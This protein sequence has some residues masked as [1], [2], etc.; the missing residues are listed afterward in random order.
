MA[1]DDQ[2]KL[3]FLEGKRP[4]VKKITR[5]DVTPYPRL[6][7]LTSFEEYVDSSLQ[8]EQTLKKHTESGHALLVGNLTRKIT[9][10]S[11]AGL[12]DITRLTRW[13][14]LDFDNLPGYTVTTAM[15]E[16]DKVW[17]EISAATRLVQYSASSGL[18]G[19][20]NLNCH[21]FLLLDELIS[22][23]TLKNFFIHANLKTKFSKYLELNPSGVNIHW[24]L[25]PALAEPSQMIFIADPNFQPESLNP[26]EDDRWVYEKGKVDEVSVQPMLDALPSM[27]ALQ[28]D[29]AKKIRELRKIAGLSNKKFRVVFKDDICHD[30]DP[31]EVTGVKEE[32]GFVYLNLNGGDSWGYYYPEDDPSI[33]RNF[34]GEPNYPLEKIAPDYWNMFV[35]PQKASHVSSGPGTLRFAFQDNHTGKTHTCTY[36]STTQELEISA[37]LSDTAARRWLLSYNLSPKHIHVV[38]INYDPRPSTPKGVDLRLRTINVYQ[39]TTIQPD[40]SKRSAR[41]PPVID[42][43][44]RHVLNQPK[45]S[46]KLNQVYEHF[47]NWLAFIVQAKERTGT[48]WLLH[49]TQGTGKG[50]LMH[51]IIKP[52]LGE[53]NCS[54]ITTNTLAEKF[55][56]RLDHKLFVGVDE[57]SREIFSK[58][59]G[60]LNRLKSMMTEETVTSRKFHGAPVEMLSFINFIL[61]S[62]EQVPIEIPANDRRFNVAYAQ[63]KPLRSA[64]DGSEMKL[65]QAIRTKIPNELPMF[66]R[67]LQERQV[68]RSVVGLAI[69]NIAKR[70]MIAAGRTATQAFFDM[71]RYNEIELIYEEYLRLSNKE[72]A[73]G[74]IMENPMLMSSDTVEKFRV[75]CEQYLFVDIEGITVLTREQ[76]AIL[77]KC[78]LGKKIPTSPNHYLA[79]LSQFGFA[80][81]KQ[82]CEVRK[83]SIK[84]VAIKCHPYI[85][86]S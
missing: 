64:F 78:M 47:L 70:H 34:K 12:T 44:I 40:S 16:L 4:L 86:S 54:V 9:D 55:T 66:L 46:K 17:P 42:L 13:M 29:Q 67:F 21:V 48:C 32:R 39:P 63:P 53:S 27:A 36:N 60:L 57:V 52:L 2:I 72:T 62:N 23:M 41:V 58:H 30:P 28:N 11:R 51:N 84:G 80:E 68:K 24:F 83:K 19:N 59:L 79:W 61:T 7:Y 3:T 56:D 22:P 33:L 71:L 18:F 38:N 25:D 45:D 69:D 6:K 35:A 74:A 1:G 31:C 75:L 10:E 65:A 85:T 73:L 5:A 14:C 8:F 49:G 26:H 20:T 82:V 76:V 15:L 43:I 50:V 37:A 77:A 81:T